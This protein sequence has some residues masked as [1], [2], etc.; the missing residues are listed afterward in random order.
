MNSFGSINNKITSETVCYY[1][2]QV[3]N[4]DI[5]C[6]IQVNGKQSFVE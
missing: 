3:F 1:S 6:K 5:M 2:T 4:L